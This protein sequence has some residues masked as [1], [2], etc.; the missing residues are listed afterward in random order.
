ML[1]AAL[2]LLYG[3]GVAQLSEGCSLLR[4]QTV[5][6]GLLVTQKHPQPDRRTVRQLFDVRPSNDG[7]AFPLDVLGE[8][9]EAALEC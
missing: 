6:P 2:G 7:S 9:R 1:S 4:I 5:A 8:G 3:P